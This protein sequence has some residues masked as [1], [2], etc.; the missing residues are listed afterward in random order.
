MKKYLLILSVFL[1]VSNY[2]TAQSVKSL[3]SLDNYHIPVDQRGA[4]IAKVVSSDNS[5]IKLAK[6]TSGLFLID[7]QGYI[8]L[9]D[10]KVLTA[11]SPMRYEIE[12]KIGKEK[13]TFEL[14]KDDFIRNGV[15]AHRGAWKHADVSQNSL[16]ALKRAIELGCAGSELDIWLSADNKIILSHDLILSNMNVGNTTL[17]VLKTIQLKGGETVPTLDEYIACTKKQNKTRLIVELKSYGKE[18]QGKEDDSQTIEARLMRTMALTDSVV[19]SVHRQ[20]AQAWVEYISFD[21]DVVLRLRQL[22]PT[23]KISYL[24]NNKKIEDLKTADISGIDYEHTSFYHNP[25]W[26]KDAHSLG[27][28]TNGWTVNKKE[29]M[30]FLLGL[31]IDYITTDEPELLLDILKK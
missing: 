30:Q 25:Q 29:Q 2:G 7:K 19:Q 14:V 26:I 4:L 15:I 3:L 20:K 6:D 1:A 22:D 23:V 27:L 28:T 24:E 31:G 11:K 13:K 12:L 17:E 9:K 16:G 18:K 8:R 21:Y 10:D 5:E